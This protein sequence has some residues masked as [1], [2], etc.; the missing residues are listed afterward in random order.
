MWATPFNCRHGVVS[1]LSIWR[2]PG[3]DAE[4]AWWLDAHTKRLL[5]DMIG[6]GD[7]VT[8]T[9]G[10]GPPLTL[11]REQVGLE[12]QD[13][14]PGESDRAR[15]HDH[16]HR[17]VGAA[18]DVA[19]EAGATSKRSPMQMTSI[20]FP[21]SGPR[22]PSLWGRGASSMRGCSSCTVEPC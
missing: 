15:V 2:F 1:T 4:S 22:S 17:G 14:F 9:V 18:A 10:P 6:L 13:D 3:A 21:A 11:P 19:A 7:T 12:V 5:E 8:F 20:Q 16:F